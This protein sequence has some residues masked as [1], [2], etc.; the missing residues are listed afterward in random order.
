MLDI[1]SWLKKMLFMVIK[2]LVGCSPKA[3]EKK[4]ALN[5]KYS[6]ISVSSSRIADRLTVLNQNKTFAS[7]F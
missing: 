2:K 7:T 3:K 1:T 6:H 4:Q 5:S